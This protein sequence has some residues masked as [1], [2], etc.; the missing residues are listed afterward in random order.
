MN[1]LADLLT[2]DV[3]VLVISTEWPGHL[4]LV[5]LSGGSL[6]VDCFWHFFN[7]NLCL[8]V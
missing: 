7:Y 3:G 6:L 5:A 1:D 8:V 2:L 4:L